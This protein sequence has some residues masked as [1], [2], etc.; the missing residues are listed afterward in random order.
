MALILCI[1]TATEICSVAIAKDGKTIAL[2]EDK[3]GNKYIYQGSGQLWD[4]IGIETPDGEF[5]SFRKDLD[6][7]P[8]KTLKFYEP[9]LNFKEQLLEESEGNPYVEGQA[10]DKV[11]KEMID[12]IEDEQDLSN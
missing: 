7:F 12:E 9:F 6:E 10:R 11:R 4:S 5:L 3:L 2:A 8:R 1:E